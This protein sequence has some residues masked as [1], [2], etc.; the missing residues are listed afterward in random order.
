M[1]TYMYVKCTACVL[2]VCELVYAIFLTAVVG[3]ERMGRGWVMVVTEWEG[4]R[5]GE[6][7]LVL[8]RYSCVVCMAFHVHSRASPVDQ[9]HIESTKRPREHVT[10]H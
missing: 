10:V 5:K 9:Q 8:V 3:I 6:K 1:M 4:E 2:H 7:K